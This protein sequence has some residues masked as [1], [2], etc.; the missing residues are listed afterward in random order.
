MSTNETRKCRTPELMV[1]M[2][3][4]P[5]EDETFNI[6]NYCSLMDIC[7]EKWEKVFNSNKVVEQCNKAYLHRDDGWEDPLRITM[8]EQCYYCNVYSGC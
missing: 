5:E 8:H 6:T 1:K 4:N 2:P 3:D 7:T